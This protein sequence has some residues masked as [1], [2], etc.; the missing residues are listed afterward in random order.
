L[1]TPDES[2]N[3]AARQ[4]EFARS[5]PLRLQ[6]RAGFGT[7]KPPMK[8]LVLSILLATAV[9]GVRAALPSPDLVAEIHFAGAQKILAA[10]NSSAFT[11]QFCSAEALALRARVADKF[12]AWLAGWLQK[13]V[14]ADAG[15]EKLRPLLD[16]LQTA[17]WFL[18]ARAAAGGRPELA[19]A[20]NLNAARAQ[21]WQANWS[22]IF[23]AG[24]S[25]V[26]GGWLVLASDAGASAVVENVSKRLSQAADNWLSL[27]VNW[28][29]LAQWCPAAKEFNLPET[30]FIVSAP[31][32]NFLITGKFLFPENLALNL[33]A[34]QVPTNLIHSPFVS[35]TATRGFADWLKAQ[36]WALDYQVTP[37]PS[38]YFVW[39]LPQIPYQ[40]FAAAPFPDS[41]AA[42]VQVQARLQAKIDSQKVAGNSLMPFTLENRNGEVA[43]TGVPFAS[44]FLRAT[45]DPS[46][47]FLLA[48]AFP[49]PPRGKSLPAELFNR[50]AE[51]NLVFYHWEITAERMPQV[52]NLSQLALVLTSHRQLDGNSP[53]MKWIQKV[54]P[55]LG[56]TVTEITQTGPAE[57]AFVRKSSGVFTAMELFALG[58]WLESP[59][60]PALDLKLPPRG[61]FPKRVHPLPPGAPAQPGLPAPAPPAAK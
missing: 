4:L 2:R 8:K 49:L 28:P 26:S 54:T 6:I 35:F 53:M 48:G 60:F 47:Q 18:E 11:N 44:P 19:V 59:A 40:T 43:I 45:H 38:E 46:G 36:S 7:E 24:N 29:R 30:Q 1:D 10:K 58:C 16:D 21:I 31:D 55:T 15:A 34:W 61:K 3:F 9:G 33:P 39:S 23:P 37:A 14:G 42:L 57:M 52:L 25:K 41:A 51:P 20:I 17:E 27:D 12:S 5:V 50:L 56:N 13:N 32:S 22:Q